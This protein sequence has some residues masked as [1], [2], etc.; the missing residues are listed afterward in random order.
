MP[1]Q[2]LSPLSRAARGAEEKLPG[3]Q[4]PEQAGRGQKV[5]RLC[6]GPVLPKGSV[7]RLGEMS[8]GRC[9]GGFARGA[10]KGNA[11]APEGPGEER[12][13][14]FRRQEG[15]CSPARKGSQRG[16]APRSLPPEQQFPGQQV[17]LAGDVGNGKFEAPLGRGARAAGGVGN[18]FD[19]GRSRAGPACG[20]ELFPGVVDAS[21][22]GIGLE[23][24]HRKERREFPDQVQLGGGEGEKAHE[25]QLPRRSGRGAEAR[26]KIPRQGWH[27]GTVRE[28]LALQVVQVAVVEV[29]EEGRRRV[30]LRA[31]RRRGRFRRCGGGAAGISASQ[32]ERQVPGG[33]IL[34]QQFPDLFAQECHKTAV[35]QRRGQGSRCGA[36]LLRHQPGEDE[37]VVRRV[38]LPPQDL[39][40][41]EQVRRLAV[42]IVPEP[43]PRSLPGKRLGFGKQR[44]EQ[45]PVLRGGDQKDRRC[46]RVRRLV[47]GEPFPQFRKA[48]VGGNG[49]GHREP[50]LMG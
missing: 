28:P 49:Q 40:R 20:P 46:A 39:L 38:D 11:V 36:A 22:T 27:G 10:D 16:E 26:Q 35:S 34:P 33:N 14:A 17:C 15:Q 23:K 47:P 37:V 25:H 12:R 8:Q 45:R 4:F 1:H 44:P 42:E 30:V 31:G 9:R 18:A 21:E 29:A 48:V 24:R 5:R 41:G 6:G 7:D 19:A 3:V 32:G 13:G 50:F 2:L 43:D